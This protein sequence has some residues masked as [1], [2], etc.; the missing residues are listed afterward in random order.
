MNVSDEA[1]RMCSGYVVLDRAR[2]NNFGA[3]DGT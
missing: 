1:R 3:K 2:T